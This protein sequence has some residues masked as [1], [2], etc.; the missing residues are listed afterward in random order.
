MTS[1]TSYPY[2]PHYCE[3]NIWQAVRHPDFHTHLDHTYAVFISN[4]IRQ[5]PIWAQRASI[6]H[7][8]P[9]V[10]DYHVIMLVAPPDAPAT[11][12]DFD[13]LIGTP[14]DFETWWATSFP[15]LEH[16]TVPYQPCFRLISASDYL[17]VF[18][19]DRRHMKDDKGNWRMPPPSWPAIFN[20]SH[21]LSELIDMSGDTPG[22]VMDHHQFYAR[23]HS[24]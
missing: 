14:S 3:E 13:T 2:T 8:N 7:G 4:A 16:L 10:W 24:S 15:F 22:L 23:F 9:V 21:N 1:P 18:S 20:G 17:S 11:T 6:I 12:W 19:S 5:C